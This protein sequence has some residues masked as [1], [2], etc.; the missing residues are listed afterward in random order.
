M[1]WLPK[2]EVF[3]NVKTLVLSVTAAAGTACA[4]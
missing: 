2:V 4:R 1:S 3:L